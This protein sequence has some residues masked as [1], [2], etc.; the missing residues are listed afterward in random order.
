[1]S[2][3]CRCTVLLEDEHVTSNVADNWQQFLHQ[4]HALVIAYC[5]LVLVAG[6]YNRVSIL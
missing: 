4:Q 3:M 5:L 2:A 1:V 6:W